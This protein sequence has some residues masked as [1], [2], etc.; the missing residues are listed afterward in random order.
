[1]LQKTRKALGFK[2][3]MVYQIPPCGEVSHIWQTAY[4]KLYHFAR[5]P[6]VRMRIRRAD[7]SVCVTSN[8]LCVCNHICIPV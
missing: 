8:F 7:T 1:M 6:Y 4:W 3:I 2:K 5:D